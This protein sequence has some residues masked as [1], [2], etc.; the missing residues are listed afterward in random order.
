MSFVTTLLVPSPKINSAALISPSESTPV[1][2]NVTGRGAPT[3]EATLLMSDV[4]TGTVFCPGI[5]VGVGV[6][7]A[8]A[9]WVG[10]GVS[11]A[12]ASPVYVKPA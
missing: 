1:Q 12:A 8:P 3:A 5:L 10:V 11:V 7:V 9:G 4:Q 2:V 6:A